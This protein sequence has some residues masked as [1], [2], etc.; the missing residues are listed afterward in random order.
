M[1]LRFKVKMNIDGLND[2]QHTKIQGAT[3]NRVKTDGVVKNRKK[4]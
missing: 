3:L 2:A 4:I 1:V